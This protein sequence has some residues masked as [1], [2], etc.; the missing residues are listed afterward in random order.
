MLR[1]ETDRLNLIQQVIN[2]QIKRKNIFSKFHWAFV[3]CKCIY[4]IDF[5]NF[6]IYS[7]TFSVIAISAL[8]ELVLKFSYIKLHKFFY[9]LIFICVRGFEINLSRLRGFF[10]T[11]T[12]ISR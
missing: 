5:L 4:N 3:S 12:V 11:A 2:Q 6:F 7:A 8:K 10:C 9:I 1:M